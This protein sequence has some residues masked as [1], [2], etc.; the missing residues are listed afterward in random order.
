MIR[1]GINKN[2]QI[3]ARPR[4]NCVVYQ[5]TDSD[6]VMYREQDTGFWYIEELSDVHIELPKEN[7]D[8]CFIR[9]KRSNLSQRL[10]Y[11]NDEIFPPQ[12]GWENADGYFSLQKFEPCDT[13]KD[14]RLIV[15]KSLQAEN[16]PECIESVKKGTR[17]K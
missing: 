1:R 4:H 16:I 14:F 7:Q 5:S 11:S 8:S 13:A 6:S 10:E 9:G 12:N 15:D 2:T 17:F 3:Y